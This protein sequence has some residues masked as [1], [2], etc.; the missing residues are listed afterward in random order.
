LRELQ[1]NGAK[2]G[3]PARR[4]T[5]TKISNAR[6]L[7]GSH[8]LK[9]LDSPSIARDWLALGVRPVPLGKKSKKP[10][11]GKGWNKMRAQKDTINQ[12]F[13]RGYNVGGLWG[14]PSGW[15]IDVDLDTEE[16]CLAAR[17]LLPETFIYGRKSA[18]GSHYLYRCEGVETKKFQT[19]EIGTIAEI[20]S[21]GTQSVLPPSV[22]PSGEVYEIYHDTDFKRI[23][24]SKLQLLL[25]KISAAALAAINWP[26]RGSRHDFL[27]A[28][29]G[30][31]CWQ[32]WD[33]D[34]ILSFTRATLDAT[35]SAGS[36]R[37]KHERTV[38]NVL[39]NFKEGNKI[40]G[41][42]ALSQWISGDNL[43][44]LKEWI[45]A[46]KTGEEELPPD[47]PP[48]DPSP[49]DLVPMD[50]E[51]L[52]VPGLVGEVAAWAQ[53]R[54]FSYQ[55]LFSLAAGLSTVA[56]CSRNKYI[57][58]YWDTPLQPYFLLIAPTAGGKE[59][60]MDSVFLAAKRAGLGENV[61]KGFQSYHAMLDTLANPPNVALMLWDECARKLKS[62]AR[63]TG[64]Q[65]Y[66]IIT[67][68]LEMYGKGASSIPGLPA[69]KNAI[70]SIDFPFFSVLAAAQPLHLLAALTEEELQLGLVN[71][72]ILLD[73][74]S[75]M[76]SMN[77]NRDHVF[78]SRIEEAL[79]RF[80]DIKRPNTELP[81]KRI[82]FESAKIW[83]LF[84]D[85]FLKC[86]D[87]AAQGGT[88]ETWGR[89][90]QNALIVAGIVAVGINP[91][92]PM[93]TES[94]A[95]WAI[96]FLTWVSNQ[97]VFRVDQSSAR[98]STERSSKYIERL[99]TNVREFRNR[100][101]GPVELG[102]CKRGLMPKSMLMRMSRN[103]RGRELDET[104]TA[105]IL[106]D[107]VATGEVDDRTCYW[108]KRDKS[109]L[110]SA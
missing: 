67:H 57:V 24:K 45:G 18:P 72:F 81:F 39:K 54:S 64:G 90:N 110:K 6:K 23:A 35:N 88:S 71:R 31:L 82:R 109:V 16:A 59:S 75:K 77:E 70:K 74:G 80:K 11:A 46:K 30:A 47:L 19:K 68:L 29:A 43:K 101:R 62:A 99:I 14:S 100:S 83:G 86:R 63:A 15:V 84:N 53:K 37:E 3:K 94:V 26:A 89:A 61:F 4:I 33:K 73:A 27:V 42:P 50:P 22:H 10:I 60:S 106:S 1:R 44:A 17:S 13:Y 91:E 76:P 95:D 87:N 93:I 105:L 9:Q 55:P 51:L 107:L 36:D 78:P 40:P 7:N 108:L 25:R 69:R 21:T 2:G 52:N 28:L 41:W 5:P 65:D 85:F 103:L 104:L 58:D 38:N 49:A 56:L 96:K 102:L 66:A 79:V 8:A 48:T 97:W 20:R 92:R 12:F 34:E 98:N 32:G